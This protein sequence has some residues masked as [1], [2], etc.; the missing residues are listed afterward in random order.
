MSDAYLLTA[1]SLGKLNADPEK[2]CSYLEKAIELSPETYNISSL[3]LQLYNAYVQRAKLSEGNPQN[4]EKMYEK[5]A[6]SLY[7]AL[8]DPS[9]SVKIE[10][11]LWLASYYYDFAKKLPWQTLDEFHWR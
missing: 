3:Q 10:N 1:L 5:A 9:Q 8:K 11:Q 2:F 7:S 6:T 4:V